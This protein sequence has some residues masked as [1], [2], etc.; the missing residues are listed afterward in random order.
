LKKWL[1][2]GIPALA[3]MG[4]LIWRFSIRGA[5]NAQVAGQTGARRNAAAAVEVTPAVR[6]VIVQSLQSVGNVESPYKVEISPKSAGRISFL[7]VRE[8]DPVKAGQV[9]LKIDPSDLQGAVS[10]AQANVAEARSRLAEAKIT[11]NANTVGVTSQVK[12]QVAAVASAQADLNQ[13][14]RNYDAQV[15]TA[16]AQVDAADSGVKNAQANLD[17]ENANLTNAQTK[18]NRTLSLYQQRFIAAQDVDDART[19]VDVEKGAVSVASGQLDAARSQLKVQNQN[20]LIVKRKG[21]SDIEAS[22]AKLTQSKALLDVATANRSQT[23]A[24]K[25]NLA[26]LQSAVDAAVG[27][28]NQAQSRL[29]DT[30]VRSSING[31]VTD[32][33]ADPGA[34]ASPGTPVLEVQFLDWLYVTTTLPVESSAAV[35]EGQSADIT[36]DALPGRKFSGTITNVNPAADPLNRQFGLSIRLEN[37]D[38][39]L[40]PGM[41][42]K[43]TVVTGQV[44]ASVVVPRE[45]LKTNSDG[46][47]TVAVVDKDNVAHVVPVKLGA[48]DEKGVQITEGVQPADK[49]VIL[50]YTPLR[51]GQK[52]TVGSPGGKGGP[53]GKGKGGRRG[54]NAGGGGAPGGQGGGGA[55]GGAGGGQ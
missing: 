49:V 44:D 30:A 2:W 51:D 35:H 4:L 25:E 46:T 34:L 8:G 23:P 37:A 28:L 43:V 40:R 20:L 26:A 29:A 55:R 7:D 50:T 38:H 41:Y 22:K 13:V 16:Q 14:Q 54:R 52:V 1:Y 27:Q 39:A 21:Q 15:Q 53:G 3:L 19:A 6:R 12:Q 33:K 18:Y 48:S 45:A 9:L 36:F 42:G 11:Q 5:A 47:T 10:Q 24:Y 31:T 17:K 32:R